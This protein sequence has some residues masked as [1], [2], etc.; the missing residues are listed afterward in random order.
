MKKISILIFFL[1]IPFSLPAVSWGEE[2]FCTIADTKA[3]KCEKGDLLYVPSHV[4]AMKLCDFG[5]KV[6]T[7]ASGDASDIDSVAIC[8]YIGYERE[9]K[10]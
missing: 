7:F 4:G 3:G 5:K 8:H 2:E 6:V 9:R 10:K 1:L